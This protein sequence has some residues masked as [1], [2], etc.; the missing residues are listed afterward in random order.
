MKIRDLLKEFT[1]EIL[2]YRDRGG[3]QAAEAAA[4]RRPRAAFLLL[5]L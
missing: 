3:I 2:K 1:A 4:R 5:L